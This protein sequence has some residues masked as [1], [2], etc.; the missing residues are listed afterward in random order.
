MVTPP[1]SEALH[2]L[3]YWKARLGRRA[4]RKCQRLLEYFLLCYS[5]VESGSSQSILGA[6][7][8]NYHQWSIYLLMLLM[9]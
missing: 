6:L 9:S 8:P 5:Q 4:S 2:P 7:V 3:S 1:L